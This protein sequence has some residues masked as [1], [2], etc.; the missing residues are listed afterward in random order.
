MFEIE[1]KIY[2]PSSYVGGRTRLVGVLVL[3][4]NG[5]IR[6]LH[7]PVMVRYLAFGSQRGALGQN[8]SSVVPLND[9]SAKPKVACWGDNCNLNDLI[10]LDEYYCKKY[11][12][13]FI[14]YLYSSFVQCKELELKIHLQIKK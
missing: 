8:C 1:I 13:T 7:S 3:P 2:W 12:L 11:N 10:T 4:N 14:I 6:L 9:T 5:L